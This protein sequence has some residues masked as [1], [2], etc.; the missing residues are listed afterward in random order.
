[1]R[2]RAERIGGV[3]EIMSRPGEGTRVRLKVP[4]AGAEEVLH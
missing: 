2:E 4:V 3:L 1:M